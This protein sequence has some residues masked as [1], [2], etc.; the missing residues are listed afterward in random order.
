[1]EREFMNE[2][3]ERFIESQEKI[4]TKK[5]AKCLSRIGEYDFTDCT[6]DD[7]ENL[8]LELKADS[9][10]SIHN[11]AY[12]LKSY[13]KFIGD[14]NICSIV[15]KIDKSK[16]WERAKPT[17]KEKFISYETYQ[18]V[19]H[20]VGM[21]EELNSF[22]YQ[23]LFRCIYEGVYSRDMSVI[24]NLRASDVHGNTVLLRDDNNNVFEIEISHELARDIK[25]LCKINVW[26]RKNRFNYFTI[27]V[28]GLYPDSCFKLEIRNDNPKNPFK[29]S[30]YKKLNHIA[31]TY[32]GFNLV[33]F[34]IYISGIVH[35]ID[36]RLKENNFTLDEAFSYK[37]RNERIH[38]IIEE[39]L[40]R[41]NYDS[42]VPNF[43]EI[44]RG[45]IDVF[46]S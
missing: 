32:V 8:L 26:E 1:M 7:I 16:L 33:P 21:Y 12:I 5:I 11:A 42:T 20:D 45:H 15:S 31:K 29:I 22:Y 17:A 18:N 27:N 13:A 24:K 19:Y 40:K 43:R 10:R 30:Y 6:Q 3:Y 23:T 38:E 46:K 2:N 4:S 37:C 28:Y 44:V 41:S 34:Q 39:E 35:R 9:I 14:D 36:L 25:E